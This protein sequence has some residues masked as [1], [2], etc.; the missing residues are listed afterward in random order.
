[1]RDKIGQAIEAHVAAGEAISNPVALLNRIAE[2]KRLEA[3][4]SS[5]DVRL[6]RKLA[7]GCWKLAELT[8]DPALIAEATEL[9]AIA[10]EGDVELTHS[11]EQGL[12]GRLL[13]AQQ[14]TLGAALSKVDAA[15]ADFIKQSEAAQT[16]RD[17]MEGGDNED[18]Q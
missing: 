1:M 2:A 7:A 11:R 6:A 17:E 14:A 18:N 10:A 5:E 4:E 13:A 3:I 8:G 12:N 9:V 16:I 15:R